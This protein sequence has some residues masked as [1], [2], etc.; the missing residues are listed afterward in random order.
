MRKSVKN[1][2]ICAL[3]ALF[4]FFLFVGI[5]NIYS[6]KAEEIEESTLSITLIGNDTIYLQKGTEYKEFGATAYDTVEGDL[7]E[8]IVI[9]NPV[10]KDT[11]GTYTVSYSVL[12]S[13]SESAS[14][15][16]TVIV[17]DGARDVKQATNAGGSTDTYFY[18]MIQSRDGC[19][20]SIGTQYNTSGYIAANITKYD[21]DLNQL[22]SQSFD[23]YYYSHDYPRDVI[24]EENGDL[25]FFWWSNYGY[26][27]VAVLDKEGNILR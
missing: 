10:N 27:N 12:N 7:T 15:D 13:S 17:F 14:V 21:A 26:D 16:R 5:G 24:E 3:S 20:V 4:A 22:W 11:V 8:D 6:V 9:E 18:K 25:V 23:Y 19:F 1:L 2:V